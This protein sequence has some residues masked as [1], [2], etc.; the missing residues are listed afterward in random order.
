MPRIVLQK[1]AKNNRQSEYKS[2]NKYNKYYAAYRPLRD[3][4]LMNH[5]LDELELLEGRVVEA[6]DVHHII[7][8]ITQLNEEDRYYYLLN[9]DNFISLSES[10][11]YKVHKHIEQL[12]PKQRNYLNTKEI[13]LKYKKHYETQSI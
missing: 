5:P 6:T 3:T 9:M 8:F 11:H 12:T 10:M 7:S 4:Y 1:E 2:S 13:Q